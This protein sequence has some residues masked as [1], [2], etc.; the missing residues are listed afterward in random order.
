MAKGKRDVEWIGGIV[1]MP[2][3]VTDEG[4]AYRPEVLV[5]MNADGVLVGTTMGK[6]GELISAASEDLQEALASPESGRPP[7]RIRVASPELATALRA[8]HPKVDVVV[9]ATPELDDVATSMR[10]YLDAHDDGEDAEQSYLAG[11]HTAEAMDSFFH[12]AA[13]LYRAKP[14]KVVPDDECLLSVSV[15]ALGVRGAVVSVI[16]QMAES[17]GFIVFES[18]ADFDRYIR[19][20]D[21]AQRGEEPNLPRH[22]SVNFDRGAELSASMRKEVAQHQWEVAAADAYPW[23]LA[24]ERD[25]VPRPPTAK[26]LAL[27]ECICLALPEVLRDKKKLMDAWDKGEPY[28][29]TVGVKAHAGLVHVAV[30]APHEDDVVGDEVLDE[31]EEKGRA[32]NET[33][34]GRFGESPEG[35]AFGSKGHASMLMELAHGFFGPVSIMTLGAAQLRELLFEIVPAKVFMEPDEAPAVITELRAFFT[36]LKREH[37][38]PSASECLRV[39]GPDAPEKLR[40]A[41]SDSSK[42]GTMKSVIAAGRDAG[43]DMS[44]K[45]GLEGWMRKLEE[46]PLP[47]SMLPESFGLAPSDGPA[48]TPRATQRAKK[49][50]RKA[51]RKARKK[52]R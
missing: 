35:S 12:A 28:E 52:N 30:R 48:Y 3:Y 50:K 14:W 51:A 13:A 7:T 5:W 20:V 22:F 25:R 10:Q 47:P 31:L 45:E 21:A 46:M 42:F 26:E 33:L 6:P 11:G 1:E 32:L 37:G 36:F 9:A 44:T 41:L 4:E 24:V 49:D 15:D 43:F 34:A 23:I 2:A 27:A 18:I 40:A 17:F 16:G 8:G 19:A 29:K 39:L 38:R